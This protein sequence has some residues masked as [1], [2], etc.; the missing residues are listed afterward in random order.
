MSDRRT[1]QWVEVEGRRVRLTSLDRVLYPNGMTKAEVIAYYTAVAPAILRQLAD[2]PVTRIRWPEGVGGETFFEKNVP[3]GAPEWLRHRRMPASP[4]AEDG[5]EGT[6]VDFPFIDDLPGLVWSANQSALELHTP[7]WRVD[8]D[9]VV[10]PPDRLVVDLDPGPPAGLDECARV[11]RL[12]ADRLAEDGLTTTYPV[13]SGS[14]GLQLYA[15]LDGSLT[16]M[17]VREYARNVAEELAA[18][19]RGV[20][21]SMKRALRPGK[22]LLD[23]SQNHP[24]KTT[25]TP[26]SL[27][28]R[29][30][31]AVAAPRSWDEV[32]PGMVHLTPDEVVRRLE[33]DGDL[34][35]R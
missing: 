16:A 13:T 14:K 25:V 8:R 23:W 30:R 11:A 4:G 18:R 19:D 2:R 24:A 12:V 10:A 6:V 5:D 9:G 34:L 20:L 31:P 28:G 35:E 17:Q 29:E 33:T 22:V 7:Q 3:A 32:G 27:R 21:A 1:V 26:Y 15:P